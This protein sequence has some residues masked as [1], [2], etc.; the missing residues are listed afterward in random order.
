MEPAPLET[1]DYNQI[2]GLL[3]SIGALDDAE[4]CPESATPGSLE[5]RV[6]VIRIEGGC[7]LIEYEQLDGRTLA[8][9]RR[10]LAE[11]PTVIAA[12]LPVRGTRGAPGLRLRERR[13]RCRP[14]VAS[15]AAGR[16]G[17]C[18]TAGPRELV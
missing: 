4:G 5:G 14:P 7:V 15:T 3:S 16:E 9:A 17:S 12:D 13:S 11:D 1:V 8:Q 10:D 18:G 6:E 2:N